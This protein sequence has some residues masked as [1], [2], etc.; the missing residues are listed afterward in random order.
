MPEVVEADL[1]ERRRRL[2]AGDVAAE[3]GRLL[4]G[5]QHRRD[6]VPA[7]ERA[8]PV[9]ELRVAGD[10]LLE[11]DR[12]RVDVRRASPRRAARRA[13]ARRRT[14]PRAGLR[15]RARAVGAHDRVERVEPLGG[16]LGIDVVDYASLPPIRSRA[17][18][19]HD[20]A[21]RCLA[22]RPRTAARPPDVL[23]RPRL[24]FRLAWRL[25][26]STARR[27]PS[28]CAGKW[29]TRSPRGWP[30]A[31]PRP[32]SRPCW[33]ATT[34]RRRCTSAASRRPPRRSA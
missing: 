33:S 27:S 6:R 26:S 25:S 3:L 15:A 29:P 9:L 17:E 13:G 34:R 21:A 12:D 7:H 11:L 5:V 31:T 19:S 24:W 20:R 8:E 16:L 2:E 1:V 18:A 4:V 23:R 28:R 32:P 10:R 14:A 22:L 30:R